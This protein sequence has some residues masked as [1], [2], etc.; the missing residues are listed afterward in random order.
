VGTDDSVDETAS[1]LDDELSPVEEELLSADDELLSA[2]LDGPPSGEV[3]GGVLQLELGVEMEVGSSPPDHTGSR[4]PTR[5]LSC[6]AVR[7]SCIST[8][9]A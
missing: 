3:P 4:R 6:R 5:A 1:L 9:S 7:H 2:G 8:S